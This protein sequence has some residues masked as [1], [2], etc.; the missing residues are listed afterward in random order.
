V[1]KLIFKNSAGSPSPHG[2]GF[3]GEVLKSLIPACRQAG[4]ISFSSWRRSGASIQN[5]AL[6]LPYQP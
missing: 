6:F 5:Q 2:E 3:K 1:Q 4:S